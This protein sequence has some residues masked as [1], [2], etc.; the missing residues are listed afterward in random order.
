MLAGEVK[1]C[2]AVRDGALRSLAVARQHRLTAPA[3]WRLSAPFESIRC[4]GA[5][6][7]CT[8]L[9]SARKQTGGRVVSSS[10]LGTRLHEATG[11]RCTYST[12]RSRVCELK[13]F[14]PNVANIG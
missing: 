13:K 12:R 2:G 14:I 3:G 10:V 1:F 8:D 6:L 5:S 11:L 9:F 4:S 7:L